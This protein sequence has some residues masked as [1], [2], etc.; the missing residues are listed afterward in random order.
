MTLKIS[1]YKLILKKYKFTSIMF[2]F[3]CFYNVT[4]VMIIFSI[5]HDRIQDLDDL[6]SSKK[7]IW[8][9]G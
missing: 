4:H 6:F 2:L 5:I 3:Y 1:I 7:I 9:P 8:Y